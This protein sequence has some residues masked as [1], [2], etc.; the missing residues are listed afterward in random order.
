MSNTKEMIADEASESLPSICARYGFNEKQ[1]VSLSQVREM[2]EKE[3]SLELTTL[4]EYTSPFAVKTFIRFS[5]YKEE[6][7][8]IR[9][10]I[11]FA[12]RAD[13]AM[14][15]DSYAGGFLE[16]SLAGNPEGYWTVEAISNGFG[17][18][19]DAEIWTL[20]VAW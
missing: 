8:S 6:D 14:S 1:S 7:D 10:Q 4:L 3:E 15:H 11:N 16:N 9:L 2:F 18:P 17:I 12:A 13:D 20:G 19:L 5:L